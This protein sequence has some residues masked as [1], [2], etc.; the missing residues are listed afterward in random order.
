MA[1]PIS[2]NNAAIINFKREEG[3]KTLEPIKRSVVVRDS[4]EG[5]VD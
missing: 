4:E 2:K 5:R 1:Y 3:S